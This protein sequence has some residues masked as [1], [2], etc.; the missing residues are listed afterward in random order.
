MKIFFQQGAD[1]QTKHP[2]PARI[3]N[4]ITQLESK[5]PSQA[6]SRP[7]DNTHRFQIRT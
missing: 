6:Q 5:T 7:F 4:P 3:V 2:L 1:A